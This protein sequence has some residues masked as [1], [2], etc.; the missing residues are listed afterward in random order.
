M[1]LSLYL[2]PSFKRCLKQLGHKERSIV[3]SILE[4]LRTYYASNCDLEQARIVQ[5]GFFYKQLWKPFYEAGI[6]RNICVV[7]RREK[8]ICYAV[9]VGNHDQIRRFL[10]TV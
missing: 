7:I 8:E 9:A 6:E 1:P 5:T 2:L 3:I 10:V 4:A